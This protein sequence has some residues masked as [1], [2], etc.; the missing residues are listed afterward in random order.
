MQLLKFLQL[1]LAQEGKKCWVQITKD[2]KVT[3]G[4]CDTFGQ[5]A[6]KVKE[7]SAAGHDAYFACATYKDASSRRV[8][9]VWACG[10]F[11]QDIDCGE[12]KPYADANEGLAA[13]DAFSEHYGLPY[14][15][16]VYSG[17]G[18][19]AY[20]P[21][22]HAIPP[23]QWLPIA[24]RLKE[25]AQQ[26]GLHVDPTRAADLASILRPPETLNYKREPLPVTA[27]DDE[28]ERISAEDFAVKIATTNDYKPLQTAK[29]SALIPAHLHALK[30]SNAAVLASKKSN[31]GEGVKEGSRNDQ[32]TKYVGMLF[33]QGHSAEYVLTAARA[34]NQ[35]NEPPMDDQEVRTIVNSIG[36]KEAEKPPAP[37]IVVG[38]AQFVRP[39]LPDGFSAKPGGAMWFSYEIDDKPVRIPISAYE[40]YLVDVCRKEREAKGSYVFA[41]YHPQNGW[42]QFS[43]ATKDFYSSSWHSIMADNHTD[44]MD[45]KYFRR[46]V[47]EAA[48]NMKETKMDAIRYEQFGWKGDYEAFLVG[49][50]LIKSGG[51]TEVAYGDRGL[52][53]RMQLMKLAPG[54]SLS[55]WTINGNKLYGPGCESHGFAL[56]ASFAAPL[57]KFVLGATD[58]G[59]ILALRS[60]G[61]GRGKTNILHA[62]SSVWGQFDGI[63]TGNADTDNAKFGI[64]S[65]SC[66]IVV[67]EEEL[68]KIDPER[69][70]SYVKRFV[71]GRDKNRAQ[72]D[73]SVEIK[74]SRYQTIMVTASNSSLYELVRQS[75]DQGAM[76]RIFEIE[77]TAPE[78]KEAFKEFSRITA[79]MLR[80]SGHAGRHFVHFLMKPGILDY[81][82]TRLDNLI[83]YYWQVL[84]TSGKDRYIAAL[85][86]TIHMAAEIVNSLELLSFDVKRIMEWALGRAL[87][88]VQDQSAADP[89]EILNQFVSEFALECTTMQEP[90]NHNKPNL[91]IRLPRTK[92][93]IQMVKS[94]NRMY[95]SAEHLKTWMGARGYSYQDVLKELMARK[96]VLRPNRPTVLSAGTDFAPTKLACWE[97]AMD[98]SAMSNS[99]QLVADNADGTI[100][101]IK[102]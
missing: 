74:Q 2:K 75:G 62:V 33:A 67:C 53:N 82:R 17:R 51:T 99:L 13:L 32:C 1:V 71:E 10:S 22:T 7:I 77:F 70:R 8:P 16:I 97:I 98:A 89:T 15:Q 56:L 102:D 78:D 25:C 18:I 12:G 36:R 21:L 27:G 76:A 88:R 46:Y 68:D 34:M 64:I 58:G 6:N 66:N 61:S 95:I 86:A 43:I 57:M 4:F 72:R 92:L 19:H 94:T 29:S 59:A 81:V 3:Q 85:M 11:W 55:A 45:I 93:I 20:W 41:Q 54:T 28:I 96:V 42:H 38:D 101:R 91:I 44:I 83:K 48:V 50:V 39:K 23:D 60:A 65:Q 49:N 31:L 90:Y 14:P 5:L 100:A 80:N 35:K 24:L 37:A 30:G 40:L 47:Q 69:A 73:G 63:T 26:F 79:D 9:N 84:E 87:L 52:E